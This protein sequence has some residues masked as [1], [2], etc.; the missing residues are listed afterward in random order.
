VRPRLLTTRGFRHCVFPLTLMLLL[1]QPTLAYATQRNVLGSSRN[2]TWKSYFYPGRMGRTCQE[3][4]DSDGMTGTETL[5]V[6]DV[7]TTPRGT[8]ITIDEGSDT[9]VDGKNIPTNAAL[10]YTITR[11]GDL[12]SSPSSELIG[13]MAAQ[14]VGNTVLPSVRHLSSGGVFS[15]TLHLLVPL[16][17]SDLSQLSGSLQPGQ[18]SLQIAISI[19]EKGTVVPTLTVPLG[20]FHDVLEV[21]SSLGQVEVT[22]AAKG[23]GGAFASALYPELKKELGNQTWYAKNNGPVQFELSGLVAHLTSCTG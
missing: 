21:T 1:I 11:S 7:T 13:G 9:Q 15:S 23:A 12:V 19:R 16:S 10:H 17:E 8:Q 6:S 18:T 20:T 5:R 3:T 4:L 22:N 14:L 2:P